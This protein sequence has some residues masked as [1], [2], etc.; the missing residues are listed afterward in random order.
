MFALLHGRFLR[1]TL[2]L[3]EFGFGSL[4]RTIDFCKL[5]TLQMLERPSLAR[6]IDSAKVENE[7]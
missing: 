3:V 6:T 1:A 5:L 4:V 7:I 2:L